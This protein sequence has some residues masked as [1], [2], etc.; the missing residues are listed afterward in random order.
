MYC[1]IGAKVPVCILEE[2]RNGGKEGRELGREGDRDIDR[3]I[4]TVRD[5]RREWGKG[6]R[7]FYIISSLSIHIGRKVSRHRRPSDSKVYTSC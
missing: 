3:E 4:E 5:R 6:G 1:D 2:G 7:I